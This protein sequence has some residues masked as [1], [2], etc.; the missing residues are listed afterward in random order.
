VVL[1]AA[2]GVLCVNDHVRAQGPTMLLA[3]A[4]LGAAFLATVLT[5]LSVVSTFFDAAYRRVLE[6]AHGGDIRP[7]LLPYAV[8]AY[9]SAL[10]SV[11]GLLG[12]IGWRA[13]PGGVQGVLM[14][15]AALFAA[16][17]VTGSASLVRITLFHARQRAGTMRA[18]EQYRDAQARQRASAPRGRSR[19]T[20]G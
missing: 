7:A 5:A 16:W 18:I 1:G 19:T 6:E 4:A 8:V 3:S 15:L 12:A 11:I 17:A 9:V 20:Q 2:A 10:A 13:L 14:G